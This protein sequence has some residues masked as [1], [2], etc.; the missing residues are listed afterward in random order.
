MPAKSSLLMVLM[1]VLAGCQGSVPTVPSPLSTPLAPSQLTATSVERP[2]RAKFVFS[3]Y[4]VT[5][6]PPGTLSTFGG[7][8]SVPSAFVVFAT[9]SGEMTHA[10]RFEGT[11]SHC[12]QPSSTPGIAAT[13]TDGTFSAV[14]ANRD[15]LTGSYSSGTVRPGAGGLLLF[16]DAFTVTGGTGRFESA[17][18]GGTE[19][20]E[21]LGDVADV[22]SGAP[23]SFEQSGSITYAPG[24]GGQ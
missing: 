22:L 17:T 4:D 5:F 14:T 7:R 11:A 9:V 6:A 16:D 21:L 10:G 24:R 3:A 12:N 19:H 15:V 23:V 13:Y 1:V 2:S 20:G 18:G 8:C